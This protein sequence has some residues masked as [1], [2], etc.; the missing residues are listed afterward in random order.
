MKYVLD[1]SVALKWVLAEPDSGRAVRLRDE[2]NTAIH[3]LIAP[4]IFTPEIA[5]GLAVAERQGRIQAGEAAIF[6]HDIIRN[7]PVIHPTAPLL[8]RAMEIS[9]STRQAVYDCI[10]VAL[11]EAEGC[12]MV[13][14]DDQLIRK[15][16]PSFPLLIRLVD[17]P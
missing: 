7:A 12:E 10:Y 1:S 9:L 16:G 5:N 17:V 15:L 3:D 4:D 14:A 13:T 8:I 6:L 2:Y 11:A